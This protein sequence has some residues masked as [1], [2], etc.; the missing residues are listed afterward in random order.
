MASGT[1]TGGTCAYNYANGVACNADS[2]KCT[3]NDSCLNGT[4][5]ADTA[6]KVTCIQ[7][8]CH[9]APTCNPT[10][11][12]CD[13]AN[14]ADGSPCGQTGCFSPG[15][16]CNGG[17]C[18]GTPKDC[19][20]VTAQ[21]QAG[22]CNAADGSCTTTNLAN[23]S[24]C[25]ASDKCLIDTMCSGGT[26]VGTP[27]VCVPSSPC[28]TSACN[29][30]TGD[31]EDTPRPAGSP[32]SLTDSCNQDASCDANGECVGSPIVDGTPCTADCGSGMCVHSACDCGKPDQPVGN[33]GST[34]PTPK[35]KG[36]GCDFGGRGAVSQNLTGA[37]LVGLFLFTVGL[38]SRRRARAHRV[39]KPR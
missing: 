9:A 31:C 7:T 30:S 8:D 3:P 19:S 21:C 16:T 18:M 39:R 11:G 36:K 32:C 2:N 4:C 29:P 17:A 13:A 38:G 37:W 35:P 10:T 25:Q 5:L 27:K 6:H 20:E 23:G 22:V 26:C 12:N 14:L 34:T 1:C 28:R 24:A 15:S 33:D